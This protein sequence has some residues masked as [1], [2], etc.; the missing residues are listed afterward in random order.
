MN[1]SHYSIKHHACGS[2]QSSVNIPCANMLITSSI[3]T[4]LIALFVT[5]AVLFISYWKWT[6]QYWQRRN[7]PYVQPQI[8]FGNLTNSIKGKEHTSV[9]LKKI[10]DEMKR[11][12][13]KHAGIYMFNKCIYFPIDLDYI[14]N[15]MTKDFH[16]FV[17]RDFYVNKKDPL[18]A[19]LVNLKGNEWKNM[20]AK[21]TPTFTSGKMKMMFQ[22]MA[23]CQN[24]LLTKMH[25]ECL[26]NKPID[27]KEVLARFTTNIIGSCAFG[28]ECKAL[29]DEDSEFR[30]YGKKMFSETK[31]GMFKRLFAMTFPNIARLFNVSLI[32]KDVA[33]FILK[34]VEDTIEYR[35]KNN[36]SRNDFLQ[37]MMNLKKNPPTD[38]DDHDGKPL[39]MDEVASQCLVFFAAGFETSSTLMSFALYEL[40]KHQDIQEK[41]RAE[42]NSVLDKHE[43]KITYDSIQDMK[44]LNQVVDG[45]YHF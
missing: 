24:D 43:K 6:Y 36:C 16:H 5:L 22:V 25:E 45:R 10:Y 23:E 18:Q 12:G 2:V 11:K 15:I 20:R 42:I 8:P 7:V 39:T 28:L 31:F 29:E 41:L 30:E 44:Y 33:D 13:S 1:K 32:H 37:L 9:T 4:D 21:L 40:A 3:T 27:I 34:I 17:D 26:K 14:R 19:H 38:I 35:E